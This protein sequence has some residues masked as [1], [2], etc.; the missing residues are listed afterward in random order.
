[1]AID[2]SKHWNFNCF[3]W[4]SFNILENITRKE[5]NGMHIANFQPTE[6]RVCSVFLVSHR[7]W[8]K[9]LQNYIV[10]L[11]IDGLSIHACVLTAQIKTTWFLLFYDFLVYC[12]FSRV[13]RTCNLCTP[14]TSSRQTEN[15][16]CVCER[17]KTSSWAVYD[18]YFCRYYDNCLVISRLF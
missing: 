8:H 15:V 6:N 10:I 9:V 14:T 16:E 4:S 12:L 1:M 7:C 13:G 3:E 17:E 11:P 2:S 5:S 18:T